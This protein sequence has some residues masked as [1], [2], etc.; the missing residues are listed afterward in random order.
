MKISKTAILPVISVICLAIAA[1]TGHTIKND[2]QDLIA[3]YG[4]VIG[5][6]IITI[7]G[8]YTNHQ[9]ESEK[10]QSENL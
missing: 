1:V 4:S 7:W 10:K 8:I 6:T 5:S 3:T 9:K 2:T